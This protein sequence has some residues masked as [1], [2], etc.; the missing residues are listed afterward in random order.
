MKSYADFK[1]VQY[2]QY[3]IFTVD[4]TRVLNTNSPTNSWQ[5]LHTNTDIPITIIQTGNDSV[6]IAG[7]QLTGSYKHQYVLKTDSDDTIYALPAEELANV[8]FPAQTAI[9][10]DMPKA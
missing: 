10:Y 9:N 6:M 4:G 8:S 1:L 5:A 3:Y 2:K 7:N